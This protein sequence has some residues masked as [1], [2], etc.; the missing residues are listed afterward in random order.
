[1]KKLINTDK[2]LKSL[3]KNQLGIILMICASFLIATGQ[4]CWKL[5][6]GIHL[7]WVSTGFFLYGL[8]AVLMIIA[9]RYGSFSVLHPMI[10]FSYVFALFFGHYILREQIY[11][12]Q[13]LGIVIIILGIICLGVGDV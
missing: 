6:D 8:G 3:K 1:M 9:F 5:A 13:I 2:L 11:S 10:S 12:L 7:L 4:M